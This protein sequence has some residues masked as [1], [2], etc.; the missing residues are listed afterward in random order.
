MERKEADIKE[1]EF[2]IGEIIRSLRIRAKL[3]QEELA[4]KTGLPRSVISAHETGRRNPSDYQIQRYNTVFECDITDFIPIKNREKMITKTIRLPPDLYEDL[5][6]EASDND[7]EVARY[8]RLLLE[9][10]VQEGFITKSMDTIILLM[11]EA[12]E[13]TMNKL[14]QKNKEIPML[15]LQ[16]L[17]LTKYMLRD[18][19]HLNSMEVQQIMSDTK[20]MAR[21]E[22]HRS[23]R[24]DQ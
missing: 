21:E 14:S 5:Q 19:L 13:R 9:K 12:L 3:K 18:A 17:Y 8:I 24:K 4:E 1:N 20:D 15:L 23:K 11:Q 2:Q 6:K 16:N 22:Y 7:M 10:G